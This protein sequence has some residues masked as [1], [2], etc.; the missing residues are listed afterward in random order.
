MRILILLILMPLIT[1]AQQRLPDNDIK[2][3]SAVN[4]K[5]I[6]GQEALNLDAGFHILRTTHG[7]YFRGANVCLDY[8]LSEKLALG[9][10]LEYSGL[11]FHNDNGWELYNLRFFPAYLEVKYNLIQ[12]KQADFYIRPAIGLTFMKYTKL[13][14]A[15][16]EIPFTVK[17]KGLYLAVSAGTILNISRRLKPLIEIGFKGFKNSVNNLDVNPHGLVLRL[18]F[19]LH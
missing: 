14:P 9:A 17:E 5:L 13:D 19:L 7:T 18:G 8:L 10:G 4:R 16:S 12:L 15:R 3:G 1:N 6:R 2:A 11:D